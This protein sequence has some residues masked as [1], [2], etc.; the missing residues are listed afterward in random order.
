MLDAFARLTTGIRAGANWEL[1]GQAEQ[2]KDLL[3]QVFQ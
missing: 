3:E 1:M 2:V